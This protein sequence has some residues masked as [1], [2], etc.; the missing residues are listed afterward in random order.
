MKGR[1]RALFL[2]AEECSE[3]A[4]EAIRQALKKNRTRVRLTDEVTQMQALLDVLCEDGQIDNIRL[5]AN[6]HTQYKR[7]KE[8]ING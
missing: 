4:K 2:L 7:Y 3:V 8:I 1:K 6:Y 5:E